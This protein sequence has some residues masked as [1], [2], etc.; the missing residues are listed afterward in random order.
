V[1][2]KKPLVDPTIIVVAI[3]QH[4]TFFLRAIVVHPDPGAGYDVALERIDYGDEAEPFRISKQNNVEYNGRRPAELAFRDGYLHIVETDEY[5][6]PRT[7]WVHANPDDFGTK[8]VKQ[9]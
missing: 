2:R 5:G 3:D 7:Y 8:A 6:P 9:S 4:D 1:A